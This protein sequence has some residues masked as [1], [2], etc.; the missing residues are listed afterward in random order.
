MVSRAAVTAA[1]ST[2]TYASV[3]DIVDGAKVGS[4]AGDEVL[5]ELLRASNVQGNKLGFTCVVSWIV[6]LPFAVLAQAPW[7]GKRPLSFR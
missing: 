4:A 5:R 3:S 7:R 1:T 2:R 6:C